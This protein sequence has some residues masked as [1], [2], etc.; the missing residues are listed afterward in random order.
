LQ[1][2]FSN[3]Y[4]LQTPISGSTAEQNLGRT[5]RAGQEAE[6]VSG[7]FYLSTAFDHAHFNTLLNDAAYVQQSTTNRMKMLIGSYTF[8]PKSIPYTAMQEMGA[9]TK[10]LNTDAERLLE[11]I[12][13]KPVGHKIALG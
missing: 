5:H 9:R 2:S 4:Y 1:F 6:E 10:H 12:L 7:T 11:G 8:K 13:E 3:S